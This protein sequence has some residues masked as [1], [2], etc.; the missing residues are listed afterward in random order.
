MRV[1]W[2]SCSIVPLSTI[3]PARMIEMRSQ[4]RS[5]SERMWL[6]SRTVAPF[7]VDSCRVSWKCFSISG[8]SPDVGSS[9]MIRSAGRLNAATIATF[10]RLP[11]L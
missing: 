5:T 2:R 10:C 6:D 9:R 11:L 3:F 4:A 7:T 8:S 1:R